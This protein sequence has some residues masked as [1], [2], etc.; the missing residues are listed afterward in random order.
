MRYISTALYLSVLL[1]TSSDTQTAGLILIE[2]DMV[3]SQ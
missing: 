2:P 3:G 1:S